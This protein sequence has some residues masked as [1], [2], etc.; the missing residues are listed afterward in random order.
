MIHSN[1]QDESNRELIRRT[2]YYERGG[3]VGRPLVVGSVL[4]VGVGLGVAVAV[5]VGVAVGVGLGAAAQY[6][7]PVFR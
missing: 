6:R 5:A 3:G 1:A 7:P 4:G 2:R